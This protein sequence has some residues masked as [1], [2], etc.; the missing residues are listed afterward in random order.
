MLTPLPRLYHLIAVNDRT[1]RRVRLTASP[2]T[3]QQCMT[4][5]ARFNLHRDVRLV[6]E[7]QPAE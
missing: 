5:K 1:Q 2:A 3:H 4:M 7:E 6:V